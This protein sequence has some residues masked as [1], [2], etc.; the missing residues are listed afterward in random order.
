MVKNDMKGS[1]LAS[2]YALDCHAWSRK[3]VREKYMLFH[4]NIIYNKKQ[5][6]DLFS[7]EK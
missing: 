4:L 2:A 5:I 3:N 6:H 1:G 7:I